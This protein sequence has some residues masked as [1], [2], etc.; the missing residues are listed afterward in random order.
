MNSEIYNNLK[1]LRCRLN[2]NETIINNYIINYEDNIILNEKLKNFLG[3]NKEQDTVKNIY[4][5]FYNYIKRENLIN[6][7][8]RNISIN[9]KLKDLFNI[10]D[11][12]NITITNMGIHINKLIQ[13]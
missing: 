1:N 12:E 5:Y 7:N 3:V 4:S 6:E 9:S 13:I 2:I 10:T 8:K 11:N